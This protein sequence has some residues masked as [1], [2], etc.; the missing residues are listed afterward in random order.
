MD[1]KK[2]TESKSPVVFICFC[3]ALTFSHVDRA[4]LLKTCCNVSP[5][6]LA[7]APPLSLY[8]LCLNAKF[9]DQCFDPPPPAPPCALFAPSSS[10]L[11]E[12]KRT[13]SCCILN[14]KPKRASDSVLNIC[15]ASVT[16]HSS[17]QQ[18]S[19]QMC[20][21]LEN[22]CVLSSTTSYFC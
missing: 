13:F 6:R 9:P 12:T 21:E 10:A 20:M 2:K 8:K 1:R 3:C 16:V 18:H 4:D 11:Q 15:N 19:L 14:Q 5:Q 7:S 22:I 17:F